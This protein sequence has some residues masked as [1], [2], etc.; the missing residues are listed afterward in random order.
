MRKYH[1]YIILKQIVDKFHL[2]VPIIVVAILVG[3]TIMPSGF[4]STVSAQSAPAKMKMATDIPESI[5]IP[6]K[7][8]SRIGTLEFFDGLPT[9]DTVTKAHDF[10]SRCVPG[11]DA[12]GIHVCPSERTS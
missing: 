12:R 5:I 3:L 4:S 6:D 8:E 2:N 1:F 10:R 9:D 11:R 7:L